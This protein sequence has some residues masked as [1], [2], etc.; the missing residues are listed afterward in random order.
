[1]NPELRALLKRTLDGIRTRLVCAE[2]FL[3]AGEAGDEVT[4]MHFIAD[5]RDLASIENPQPE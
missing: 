2:S 5:I 3:E 4:V 1:M